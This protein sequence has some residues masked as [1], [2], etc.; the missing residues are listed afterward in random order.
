[1]ETVEKIG[2]EFSVSS[3]RFLFRL[4]L[5]LITGIKILVNQEHILYLCITML[6][7]MQQLSNI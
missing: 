7:C 5:N 2:G 1:M 3:A 6:S 4:I